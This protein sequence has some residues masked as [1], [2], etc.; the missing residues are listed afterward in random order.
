MA[1]RGYVFANQ[2]AALN[3]LQENGWLKIYLSP[4]QGLQD[5]LTVMQEGKII[6]SKR[7]SLTPLVVFADSLQLSTQTGPLSI[8]L[9]KD[10]LAWTAAD[11]SDN[12]SRP[13][14]TAAR[15]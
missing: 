7:I 3:V 10:K 1:T 15:I 14:C 5:T 2:L 13:S 9:G 6:Y 8:R 12:I 11:K 4:V